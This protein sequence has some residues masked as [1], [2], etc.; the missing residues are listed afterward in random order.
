[1]KIKFVVLLFYCFLLLSCSDNPDSVSKKNSDASSDPI[2]EKNISLNSSKQT[3]PVDEQNALGR[4]EVSF[5]SNGKAKACARADSDS[6]EFLD[7]VS[8]SPNENLAQMSLLNRQFCIRGLESNTNY[9]IQILEGAPIVIGRVTVRSSEILERNFTITS[10]GADIG[11]S[12]SGF[13]LSKGSSKGVPIFTTNIS[14]IDLSLVRISERSIKDIVQNSYVSLKKNIAPYQLEYI[15]RQ[16]G[17]PVWEGKYTASSLR[18][19]RVEQVLP[20]EKILETLPEGLFLLVAREVQAEESNRNLKFASQWILNTNLGVSAARYAKGM[21]V[22]VRALDTAKPITGAEV[23]LITQSNDIIFSGMTDS[24]GTLTLPEPSVRGKQANAPSHLVVRSKKDFAFLTLNHAALDLSSLDIGGRVLSNYGDAY[25]FTDR[26]IYRPRETV[27]LTGLIRNKN[28]NTDGVGNVNLVIHRPNGSVYKKLFPK[29]GHEA[30]FAQ[31]F[32][33]PADSPRGSWRI[34]VNTIVANNTI[35]STE[36]DVQD[37]IPE[38]LKIEVEKNKNLAKLGD[39]IETHVIA[40]FLYGA[41]AS[42]LGVE[43]EAVIQTLNKSDLREKGA[44]FYSF[45]DA[46]QPFNKRSMSSYGSRTSDTGHSIVTS[47]AS[48]IVFSSLYDFGA[49]TLPLE[50]SVAIGVQEP[51]GR[52]TKV[53][54]KQIVMGNKHLIGVRSLTGNQISSTESAVFNVKR[55]DQDFLQTSVDSLRWQVQ[56]M[57]W[58][59]DYDYSAARWRY[60]KDLSSNI[61]AKGNVDK[62]KGNQKTGKIKLP[63][64]SWGSYVLTVY[65]SKSKIYNRRIIRSGWSSN[66]NKSE[67]DFLEV[68]AQSKHFTAGEEVDIGVKSPFTGLARLSVWTD[69]EIFAQNLNVTKGDN[70]YKLKTDASW[71]PGAYIVINAFRPTKIDDTNVL[72][73]ARYM[74]VR[75]MGVIYLDGVPNNRRLIVDLPDKNMFDPRVKESLLIKVPQLAGKKGYAVVQAVD[76]GILQLTKFR[77]PK[78]DLHFFAKRKLDPDFYDDYGKLL[79][80]DGAV[81]DIRTGSGSDGGSAGGSSLPVVPTKSVVIYSGIIDLD[82]NGNANVP[83]DLPDFNGSLR[84]MVTVWTDDSYGA[85][86]TEW[87]VRDPVVSELVLPRYIAPGDTTSGTLILANTT[88]KPLEIKT[89]VFSQGGIELLN[90][91]PNII[92]LKSGERSQYDIEF[93]SEETG[94]GMI[95]V[96]VQAN[97]GF[98]HKRTW[99]IFSRY[100]GKG[101]G[102][103]GELITIIPNTKKRV[104]VNTQ[105]LQKLGRSWVLNV[106][107]E[108]DFSSADVLVKL[109]NYPWTC[110]E[111]TVSKAGPVMQA[112]KLDSK[113]VGTIANS[114]QSTS[115]KVWLQ[116]N[117]DRIISR[118]SANGAIGLWYEG[119]RLVGPSLS[120]YLVDFLVTAELNGFYLP[121]GSVL[122]AYS[123]SY[124]L[125]QKSNLSHNEK[126]AVLSSLVKAISPHTKR[127]VRLAR[128][129]ADD[130]L[131]SATSSNKAWRSSGDLL[132]LSNLAVA[133]H[134]FGDHERADDLSNEIN[135]QINE[136][137]ADLAN[138]SYGGYYDTTVSRQAKLAENLFYLKNENALEFWEKAT[139]QYDNY[140]GNIHEMGS[141]LR[142]KVAQ[143]SL[144]PIAVEVNGDH[145]ESNLGSLSIPVSSIIGNS[146]S[147]KVKSHSDRSLYAQLYVRAPPKPN[148]DLTGEPGDFEISRRIFDFKSGKEIYQFKEAK[149]NDRYIVLLSGGKFGGSGYY[150]RKILAMIKDPVPAG[151]QIESIISPNN[152]TDSFEFLPR[153]SYVNVTEIN[154][155]AFFAANFIN[156]NNRM[157][158][159]YVI[160][161]TTP[162]AYLATQAVMENMY[163]PKSF[164][165]SDGVPIRVTK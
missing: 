86:S 130:S 4:F 126:T 150:S 110:S 124:E 164:G 94:I 32:K 13:I 17:V 91:I 85:A 131:D 15:L 5:S 19:V 154:D 60:S 57:Y 24:E 2:I 157:N 61:I 65:D 21:T 33:L 29:L 142:A 109:F 27:H 119:D 58:N 44:E 82:T 143:A 120:S 70:N 127:S 3:L 14:E 20:I 113:Y 161:A 103:G 42:D 10:L 99:E 140:D 43:A 12:D 163:A 141:M 90:Q 11:F 18:N 68:Q 123:W 148:T 74:P 37:F 63:A 6:T 118:Q 46:L 114:T 76:E 87:V 16:T 75:A 73:A 9:N 81:G 30:S 69:R 8:V 149:V 71:F 125:T 133:L 38:R 66:A 22:N 151:F 136:G 115:A 36:I 95:E 53:K 35:G 156:N 101:I 128:S 152:N 54:S 52:T 107:D 83:L 138:L 105:S 25:L 147:V 26:G 39:S 7:F 84:T 28:A 102:L 135:N 62:F 34:D 137:K 165:T 51:G 56:P 132:T 59:W 48:N 64:L 116:S 100:A 153:L 40:K 77:T 78:P 145:F 88:D 89:N 50:I 41:P 134:Q 104:S 92:S 139:K 93:R 23:N 55:W 162:G 159:A 67:P 121:E 144:K 106:S 155:D 117:V 47:E 129:L 96:A 112:Y 160:R 97:N 49:A 1:M 111:Q 80:G 31:E 79:R 108:K 146:S 158:V 72:S 122:R 45:G 98:S